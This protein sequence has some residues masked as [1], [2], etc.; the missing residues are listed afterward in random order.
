MVDQ[1]TDP[2]LVVDGHPLHRCT[3]C[4]K[5]H[6]IGGGYVPSTRP[7]ECPCGE[8]FPPGLVAQWR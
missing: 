7:T 3:A 4:G 2:T 5:Q 6:L 8:P 1:H